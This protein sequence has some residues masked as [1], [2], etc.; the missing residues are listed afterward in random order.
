MIE[1]TLNGGPAS[2]AGAATT[3]LVAVLRE[4]LRYRETH[5]GGRREPASGSN[6]FRC[7]APRV[8]ES[9]TRL[10]PPSERVRVRRDSYV[11]LLTRAGVVVTVMGNPVF[12]AAAI[13]KPVVVFNPAPRVN[14]GHE[15]LRKELREVSARVGWRSLLKKAERRIFFNYVGKPVLSGS[16]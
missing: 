11:E 3:P 9:P 13:G 16:R 15:R 7:R 8:R 10:A 6:A 2:S 4:E 14:L 12:H 1:F 5:D